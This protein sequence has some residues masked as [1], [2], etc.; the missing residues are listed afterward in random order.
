MPARRGLYHFH[1]QTDHFGLSTTRWLYFCIKKHTTLLL[2]YIPALYEELFFFF[3]RYYIFSAGNSLR[4]SR[5]VY[6]LWSLC[7]WGDLVM[8]SLVNVV[9]ILLS[10][11]SVCGSLDQSPLVPAVVS[12]LGPWRSPLCPAADI[13]SM[14]L[15]RNQLWL[16]W[17]SLLST[18]Y[19]CRHPL[20]LGTPPHVYLKFYLCFFYLWFVHLEKSL[21]ECHLF[22]VMRMCP[23]LPLAQGL[24]I[25]EQHALQ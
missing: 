11:K 9:H 3:F 25:L 8:A 15:L 10:L 13:H 23:C 20:V 17:S 14:A 7:H 18:Y 19:L 4:D 16:H 21:W 6:L 2:S 22:V 12:L 1:K 5:Y 24:S